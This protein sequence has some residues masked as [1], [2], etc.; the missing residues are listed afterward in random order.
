M[1]IIMFDPTFQSSEVVSVEV[2]EGV[3]LQEAAFLAKVPMGD[4]CGG[5]CG[6]STCHVH[7]RA[8]IES[9]EEMDDDEDDILCK[10]EDVRDVSR[11]GCQVRVGSKDLKV[12]ITRESQIAFLNEHPE[13]RD[14]LEENG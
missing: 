12:H 5:N 3:T 8:G 14:L 9:L 7:V 11:L 13:M 2:E 4:A 6:C 1:P 10:A